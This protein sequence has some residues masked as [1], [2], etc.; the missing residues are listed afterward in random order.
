MSLITNRKVK[1]SSNRR[2]KDIACDDKVFLVSFQEFL[3]GL[4]CFKTTKQTMNQATK[5]HRSSSRCRERFKPRIHYAYHNKRERKTKAKSGEWLIL[6]GDLAEEMC[7][8]GLSLLSLPFPLPFLVSSHLPSLL[9]I[10]HSTW[11]DAGKQAESYLLFLWQLSLALSFS[12]LPVRTLLLSKQE[13]CGMSGSRAVM[14][15]SWHKA[16]TGEGVNCFRISVSRSSL[17]Y[18][19]ST[20]KIFPL[21]FMGRICR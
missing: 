11:K 20:S 18:G 3:T 12:G 1:S 6:Q 14:E 15:D 19:I 9:L 10:P 7:L 17:F 4:A 13:P 2:R 16:G 21:S 8:I 5:P